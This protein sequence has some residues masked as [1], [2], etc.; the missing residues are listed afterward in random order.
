MMNIDRLRFRYSSST[1]YV[2]DGL[3]CAFEPGTVN[4]IT[5][6]SGFGKS[7][8]LYLMGLMITPTGGAVR[9]DGADVSDAPDS[10][11]SRMRARDIG[12]VFQDAALDTARSVLD[13]IVEAGLYAG[14][15]RRCVIRSAED[16]MERFSVDLQASHRPGAISGG[17]AQRVA[18]CRALV[19]RPRLILADEPTGNLDEAASEIVWRALRNS[20]REDQ[21]IVVIATHDPGL[22]GRADRTID[23]PTA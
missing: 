10:Q 20:A 8:L 6:P 15:K 12:F 1:D 18:L 19:K 13:N 23:L 9:W 4:A 22:A 11:R 7:T 21:S 3:T 17:Q 14:M 5:G 16:L 2:I